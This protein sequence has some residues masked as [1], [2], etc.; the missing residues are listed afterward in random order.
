M[1][2]RPTKLLWLVLAV[3]AAALAAFSLLPSGGGPL[4]GW[5]ITFSPE[6]QNLLHVPAY[7]L[8]VWL[9]ARATGARRWGPALLA[10]AGGVA[11]GVAL[12]CAQTVIPGRFAAVGDMILN[13]AG[14][15]MGA[16]F[17]LAERDPADEG[18]NRE[19][20]HAAARV[21]DTGTR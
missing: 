20:A 1:T 3:Y 15:G 19:T 18:R 4:K 7:G 13:A 2:R 5:D 9:G 17:V 11:F 16:A 12:E 21:S 14:A 6:A 8:L 10:M